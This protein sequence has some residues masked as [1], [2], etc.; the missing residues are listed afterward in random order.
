MG[1]F[2][3]ITSGWEVARSSLQN[4]TYIHIYCAETFLVRSIYIICL[5]VG[6]NVA[7]YTFFIQSSARKPEIHICYR[8]QTLLPTKTVVQFGLPGSPLFYIEHDHHLNL[9]RAA[10]VRILKVSINKSDKL[11]PHRYFS[12]YWTGNFL[13]V[14]CYVGGWRSMISGIPILCILRL[15]TQSDGP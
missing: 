2:A 4:C 9:T 11:F 12:G 15:Q 6:E 1:E 10:D 3:S 5:E 8:T 7:P 13:R 14:G